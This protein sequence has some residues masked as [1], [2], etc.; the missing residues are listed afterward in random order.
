MLRW[1]LE[2]LL[3]AVVSVTNCIRGAYLLILGLA[4]L[5]VV[6]LRGSMRVCVVCVVAD[7]D[8]ETRLGL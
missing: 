1:Y 4:S 8:R 3:L 6:V 7:R 5:Q 2:F